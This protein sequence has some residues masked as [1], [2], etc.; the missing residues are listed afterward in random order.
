MPLFRSAVGNLYDLFTNSTI[1][2][3]RHC[4]ISS[5]QCLIISFISRLSTIASCTLEVFFLLLLLIKT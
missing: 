2:N 1:F 5:Q 3:F 4:F